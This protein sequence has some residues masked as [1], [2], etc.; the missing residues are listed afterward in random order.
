[1]ENFF[2]IIFENFTNRI[3]KI[4]YNFEN[5]TYG[6]LKNLKFHMYNFENFI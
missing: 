4:S 1:M 2:Y 3:L 6:I 5:F